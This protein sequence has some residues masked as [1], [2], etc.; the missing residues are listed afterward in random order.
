MTKTDPLKKKNDQL[1][2][3]LSE[4]FSWNGQ[5]IIHQ[6]YVPKSP[7][8]IS[9]RNWKYILQ[10]PKSTYVAQ[11]AICRNDT[12]WSIIRVHI[13]TPFM[14]ILG[15][16]GVWYIDNLWLL[17]PIS[18]KKQHGTVVE[19]LEILWQYHVHHGPKRQFVVNKIHWD[20]PETE[21]RKIH[22]RIV[23]IIR[24]LP[25]VRHF[26]VLCRCLAFI[27]SFNWPFWVSWYW[28]QVCILPWPCFILTKQVF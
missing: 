16:Y 23:L 1:R 27:S 26:E 18:G 8:N 10:L 28:P 22:R 21:N 5:L 14:N 4:Y 9:P 11:S 24:A 12:Q 7:Q 3:C 6:K 2:H 17:Q 15:G 20:A 19:F 13:H 25:I